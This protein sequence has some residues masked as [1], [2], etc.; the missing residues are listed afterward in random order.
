MLNGSSV[1]LVFHALGDPS[2]R[3]IVEQ[4]SRKASTVSELAV[5]L[6][7]TLAAVTQHLAV[8]EKSGLVRSKKIGRTRR[9]EIDPGGLA[10]VERWV[11][12]RRQLWEQ[13]FDQLEQL[14]KHDSDNES[15]TT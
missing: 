5:P 10:L 13:C 11:A 8:L 9:C 2:R 14:L 7:V 6:G 12:E 1:D 4:L 15:N 3:A